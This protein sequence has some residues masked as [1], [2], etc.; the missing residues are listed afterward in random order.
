[1]SPKSDS[2]PAVSVIVP[3]YNTA[4]YLPRCLDSLVNQTLDGIEIVIVDDASTD[5]SLEIAGEYARRDSRIALVRHDHNAG[6]HVSRIDGV[7][8]SS[9]QYIAYVD[10][11]DCVERDMLEAMYAPAAAGADVVRGGAWLLREPDVR[12][13]ASAPGAL[14]F[15]DRAYDTGIEYLDDDFYPP[16]WLHLHKRGLWERALPY[17]PRIRLVG[18]DNLTS[19]VL[20]FFARRVVSLSYVGY[21][22]IERDDS[23]SGDISLA[24]ISRHITDRATIVKLLRRFVDEFGGSA[25]RCLGRIVTDNVGL[26]TGYIDS[27]ND[28]D[29][30]MSALRLFHA[31]WTDHVP[32][33]LRTAPIASH[34]AR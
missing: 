31:S 2:T 16:M 17:F 5:E 6:L 14:T 27:L 12:V 1:M 23:L 30:R 19:F 32:A 13:Q 26:L 10:S 15:A 3:V 28:T 8:A 33:A 11:D 22:Y 29:E 34:G 7:V 20:A 18:E 24:G 25:E 21:R 4:R 9:G